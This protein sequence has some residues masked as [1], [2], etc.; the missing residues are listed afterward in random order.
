MSSSRKYRHD[1]AVALQYKSD[2]E[3]APLVSVKAEQFLADKVISLAKKHSIPIVEEPAL[4][5]SLH[6][7]EQDQEIPEELYEPVALILSK[8]T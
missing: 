8:L 3:D 4:A 1:L 5:E 2:S 6:Q 7:L